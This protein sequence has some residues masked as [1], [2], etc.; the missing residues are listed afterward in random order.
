MTV[1]KI[2]ISAVTS[3]FNKIYVS[4]NAYRSVPPSMNH[5]YQMKINYPIAQY[6]SVYTYTV[7]PSVLETHRDAYTSKMR[8]IFNQ[9][10]LFSFIIFFKF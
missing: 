1:K 5:T 2:Y 6:H 9:L 4:K 3:R 10:F 7:E 8:Q